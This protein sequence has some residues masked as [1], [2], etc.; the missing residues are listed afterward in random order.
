M[1]AIFAR[2]ITSAKIIAIKVAMIVIADKKF[3]F[4]EAESFVK[5]IYSQYAKHEKSYFDFASQSFFH[6]FIPL[7]WLG[8]TGQ[9]VFPWLLRWYAR[10]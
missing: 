3:S 2:I 1:I 10:A 7:M 6:A 8:H 4:E 5:I 9:A